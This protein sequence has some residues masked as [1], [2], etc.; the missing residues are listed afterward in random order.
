MIGKKLIIGF[1]I[2]LVICLL[3]VSLMTSFNH[4][5]DAHEEFDCVVTLCHQHSYGA[6]IHCHDHDATCHHVHE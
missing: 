6:E 1:A 4:S 3:S 2:L 5:A